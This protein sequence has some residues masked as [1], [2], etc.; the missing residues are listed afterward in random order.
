M[1]DLFLC[2][3]NPL[4]LSPSYPS[5]FRT[6][7]SVSDPTDPNGETFRVRQV[8]GCP[9]S[10]TPPPGAPMTPVGGPIAP[11]S[12]VVAS[13]RSSISVSGPDV[14]PAS[15][16]PTG[17]AAT[18]RVGP[19][20]FLT[21][22]DSTLPNGTI[23][24]RGRQVSLAD[25]FLKLKSPAAALLSDLSAFTAAAGTLRVIVT[26]SL[27]G[28]ITS[29]EATNATPVTGHYNE[30]SGVFDLAGTFDLEGLDATISLQLVFDFSNRP[31]Q[32]NAGPDQVVECGL[33]NRSAIVH[34]SAHLSS[35]LD[36]GDSI[37]DYSWVV[38]REVI[39]TGPTASHAV[40]QVGLGNWPAT[41]VVKDSTGSTSRDVS[42][43]KVVDRT[44][45]V[46]STPTG[47]P[48]LP[49][50]PGG[51][52]SGI[53]PPEVTDSCGS[54]TVTGAVITDGDQTLPQ[55]I[56]IVNGQAQLSVGRH[57]IFWVATDQSGN[58]DTITQEINVDPFVFVPGAVTINDC[59]PANLGG[60]ARATDSCGAVN[61]SS[62]AL[63]TYPLGTTEVMWTATDAR[64]RSATATQLVTVNDT[65]KPTI[66]APAART[67]SICVGANIGTPSAED[68]CGP[69]DIGSNA[70]A[71]FPLGTTLVIW[72]ATDRSG[73][74][75]P[76]TQQVT[77][78]LGED[79]SCCP[80]GSRIINGTQGSDRL[81]GTNDSDCILGHGGDDVIDG[82]GGSDAISGGAGRDTIFAGGGNDRVYG[83]DGDDTINAADGVNFIDGGPGT[84]TCFVNQ[85]LDTALRCNP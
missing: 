70:P 66:T 72:T 4:T 64:G 32:A 69:V 50:G 83:G 27:G 10:T 81:V 22:L 82:R 18:G 51:L 7:Q 49:C 11:A 30:A 80:T 76:G 12:S 2:V 40:A 21:Q 3:F 74:V 54:V 19:V 14:S 48:N 34:L 56:T 45:P 57:I 67:I 58:I 29:V 71:K 26:G 61:I 33:S 60:P 55:P 25:G 78:V 62:N 38:G 44:R 46:F 9:F 59:G 15:A 85:A 20:L 36:P 53:V 52:V 35:E 23:V 68:A 47:L 5:N 6:C 31:P 84:D 13:S 42:I 73:N 65:T 8:R 16:Q 28:E 39:A 77:A 75:A 17:A 41:L 63:A 79:A 37:V 1:V 24:V 43:I